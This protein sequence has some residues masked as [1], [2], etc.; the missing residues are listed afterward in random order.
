M[1][2]EWEVIQEKSFVQHQRT[3]PEEQPSV[4]KNAGD[5]NFLLVDSK[6]RKR[7]CGFGCDFLVVKLPGELLVV[8][9]SVA[10]LSPL[11]RNSWTKY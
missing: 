6:A 9:H 5:H 2:S 11:L 7:W 10:Q 8:G 4:T 3:Q 1:S